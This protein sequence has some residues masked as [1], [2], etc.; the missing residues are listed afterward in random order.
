MQEKNVP[1]SG[2]L[3]EERNERL[4]GLTVEAM[5]GLRR[6]YLATPQANALKH[7]DLLTTRLRAA[8]RTTTSPEE[9]GTAMMRRLGVIQLGKHDSRALTELADYV[10]DKACA[11]QWLD[12]L[13]R[14][15]GYIMALTRLAAEKAKEERDH[16]DQ[17]T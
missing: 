12:L 10:R 17:T 6:C 7:W 3:A 14:E 13:E 16:A 15:H 5:L 2:A 8:A 4:R 1:Q 11:R 9:W